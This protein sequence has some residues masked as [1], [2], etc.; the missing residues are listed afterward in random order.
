M[1][2]AFPACLLA[3][4]LGLPAHVPGG[5]VRFSLEAQTNSNEHLAARNSTI[6]DQITTADRQA[7]S[8]GTITGRVLDASGVPV[9]NM[10]VIPVRLQFSEGQRR[11]SMMGGRG[12]T[13]A[14]STSTTNDRGEYRLFGLTPGDYYV[15][16]SGAL[17]I[18]TIVGADARSG[19][20]LTFH[21]DAADVHAARRIHLSTGHVADHVDIVVRPARLATISG[22]VVDAQGS[23][24]SGG[25]VTATVRPGGIAIRSVPILRDGTFSVANLGPGEYVLRASPSQRPRVPG[26]RSAPDVAVA[27]VTLDGADLTGVRVGPVIPVTISGRVSFDD[28][29]EARSL[30]PSAIRITAR[31]LDIAAQAGFGAMSSTAQDDWSFAFQAAPGPIMLRADVRSPAPGSSE[32]RLKAAR[33]NG[34]D[35]TDSGMTSDGDVRGVEIVLTNRVQRVTGTVRNSAGARVKE[36]AVVLFAQDSTRWSAALNRHVVISRPNSDG[37][38]ETAALPAGQYYAVALERVDQNAWQDPAFLEEISGRGFLFS[39]LE[40]ER[41]TID[42]D[43]A[44]V[45]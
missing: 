23:P 8:G 18:G 17:Q 41:R 24:R 33:V 45:Q 3:A 29:R 40:G 43:L 6:R 28:V 34:I 38:F 22:Y 12:S 15:S 39:L 25:G 1:G 4:I 13:A 14:G 7:V 32:W 10:T 9:K 31:P 16:V 11:L 27:V 19:Y 35:V 26:Q 36:Y 44:A 30:T 5:Y 21:P 42:L 37:V 2:T 20:A